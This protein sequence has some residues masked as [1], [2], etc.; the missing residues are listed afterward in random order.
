MG[1]SAAFAAFVVGCGPDV[2][3][4]PADTDA[5][6]ATQ[7]GSDGSDAADAP[8]DA[9]TSGS[10]SADGV[11]TTSADDS[12]GDTGEPPPETVL[13]W[14]HVLARGRGVERAW[15]DGE[16]IVA[17][18]QDSVIVFD[19]SVWSEVPVDETVRQVAGDTYDDAW[20][21]GYE[22]LLHWDGRALE[23]SLHE[24]GGIM[25]AVAMAPSGAPW[26]AY[27]IAD[28][29]CLGLC[30]EPPTEVVEHIGFVSNLLPAP[31]IAARAMVFAG[32]VPFI[33][34]T[35]GDVV[36]RPTD[37]PW[38]VVDTPFF[39][40]VER[41]WWAGGAVWVAA[42]E[43]LWRYEDETWTL[44]FSTA[45]LFDDVTAVVEGPTGE[46]LV[47]QS[48][49]IVAALEHTGELLRDTGA[50]WESLATLAA[51]RELVVL[52]DGSMVA[53][54]DEHGQLVQT[55]GDPIGTPEIE[56]VFFRPDLGDIGS[57]S[58]TGD[59]T[60]V[61]VDPDAVAVEDDGA[62]TRTPDDSIYGWH[63][64]AWGETPDD[65]LVVDADDDTPQ[66]LLRFADGAFT[67]LPFVPPGPE[68]DAYFL[69]DIW[70]TAA[71]RVF[72]AG[73]RDPYWA[74]QPD[75]PI[76]AR[77]DGEA[78]T[79]I[80]PP[81]RNDNVHQHLTG[82]DGHG[83]EVW[84]AGDVVWRFDGEAWTDVTPDVEASFQA[85]TVGPHGA[86]IVADDGIGGARLLHHVDDAW[87]DETLQVPGYDTAAA[88]Y[89]GLRVADD[90]THVWVAWGSEAPGLAR[91]DGAT[92]STVELPEAWRQLQAMTVA[93]GGRLVVHTGAR[94]WSGEPCEG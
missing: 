50:G 36:H 90:A 59:G 26:V 18:A 57:L 78:W 27:T 41:M 28:E 20:L 51:D 48:T 52:A 89:P 69:T 6:D 55:I 72:V 5:P 23:V 79:E 19:G 66:A 49:Q 2:V 14:S 64:A 73:W 63:R 61:G 82:V 80:D 22:S 17:A 21:L 75:A 56:T 34:G 94:V 46:I 70:G 15:T 81:S 87:I 1:W 62:W 9:S 88:E 35:S 74:L 10:G 3:V 84:A 40:D 53:L 31:G 33:G 4:P 24:E 76:I 12:T 42:G 30:P 32:D 86:W 83:D 71:D 44:A 67:P 68:P 38:Q 13:C 7:G 65:L 85:L 39:D 60:L 37:G 47:L 45:S 93:P 16:R 29:D 91:W 8:V 92:W 58:I 77:F 54:G 25:R 43:D 11:D